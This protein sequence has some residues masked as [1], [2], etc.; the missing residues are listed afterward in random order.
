LPDANIQKDQPQRP[1]G[2]FCIVGLHL[3]P[4]FRSSKR[5]RD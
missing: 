5:H 2:F 1:S 3:Q 4:G